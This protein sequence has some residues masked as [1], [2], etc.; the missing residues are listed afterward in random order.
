MRD[1]SPSIPIVLGTV[2]QCPLSTDRQQLTQIISHEL[3]NL[4]HS[5]P[6]TPFVILSPLASFGERLV[7]QL[8]IDLLEA[9]LLVPLPYLPND[10][11]AQGLLD[12]DQTEFSTLFHQAQD[13]VT[14][15]T[16]STHQVPGSKFGHQHH[17]RGLVGAFVAK[18]CQILIALWDG[19]P[20]DQDMAR[21]GEVVSW[22][23]QGGAPI[24]LST[25]AL[26]FQSL[27]RPDPGLVI[28]I[29]PLT[30]DVSTLPIQEDDGPSHH[31][32]IEKIEAFNEKLPRFFV[33]SSQEGLLNRSRD[34][35][36]EQCG[37]L[38]LKN[39]GSLFS[40]IRIHFAAAD[41][42]SIHYRDRYEK[43]IRGMYSIFTIAVLA[44]G[45]IDF[46]GRL[47]WIYLPF[48]PV[49]AWFAARTRRNQIEE[50]YLDSRALAEGLRV[51]LF[52]RLFGIP[53]RVSTYYLTKH[54]GPLS[55][56]RTAIQ[57]IE[58]ISLF[59][60]QPQQKHSPSFGLDSIITSWIDT[61]LQY[62]TAK[63]RKLSRQFTW[64]G[65]MANVW[66]ILA[67]LCAIAYG[68][69]VIPGMVEASV[70]NYFQIGM[71]LLASLGLAF[72]AY[73]SRTVFEDEHKQYILSQR[74]F[75]NA[76]TRLLNP[77]FSPEQTLV[78]LG[79]EALRENAEWLWMHRNHPLEAPKG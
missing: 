67:F 25:E 19:T 45:L 4:R 55:W 6:H 42:L 47:I 63:T 72:E 77:T 71:G 40:Q 52:W 13:W 44:Y 64:L 41:L 10:Y 65:N 32:L 2:S 3:T 69:V 15:P 59:C 11:Q 62:F 20:S 38:D 8:A 12:G 58:T 75:R 18:H 68:I 39:S 9:Q 73:R 5:Y 48:I 29:H 7:A 50:W 26:E 21:T 14:L 70:Q 22:M 60:A 37:K 24:E 30:Y 23:Q 74:L 34:I 53:E 27:D 61:Q 46:D 51:L 79:K 28:Q 66:F 57:N 43:I 31:F 35:L 56:V 54:I 36:G 1:H 17:C 16:N 49:I 33:D 76:K 78:L